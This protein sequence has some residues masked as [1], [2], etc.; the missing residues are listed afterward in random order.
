MFNIKRVIIQ[1]LEI[2]RQTITIK[3]EI[4]YRGT[5]KILFETQPKN[6]KNSTKKGNSTEIGMA[7]AL[8]KSTME[9]LKHGGGTH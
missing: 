5:D 6:H 2:D 9:P 8:M 3:I 1:V 7:A 4:I